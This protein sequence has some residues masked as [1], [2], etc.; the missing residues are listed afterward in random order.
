MNRSRG[1]SVVEGHATALV[2]AVLGSLLSETDSPA[3]H[4][5]V[6]EIIDRFY[7]VGLSKD[8]MTLVLLT[9]DWVNAVIRSRESAQVSTAEPMVIAAKKLD[10][11]LFYMRE[12]TLFRATTIQVLLALERF[13]DACDVARDMLNWHCD[14]DQ[15]TSATS[16]AIAIRNPEIV[17]RL[18]D[19]ERL[20]ALGLLD[21][22]EPQIRDILRKE[23]GG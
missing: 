4:S 11:Q 1:Q 14:A 5:P 7:P 10:R 16:V 15:H 22:V 8:E 9:H 2:R 3:D 21:Y 13:E 19:D 17:S 23:F 6:R 12:Q 18:N 20:R